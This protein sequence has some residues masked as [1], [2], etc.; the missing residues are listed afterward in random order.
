MENLQ[1][2]E[3]FKT[4]LVSFESG[5]GNLSVRGRVFPE[6]PEEFFSLI[7]DWLK[8][9]ATQPAPQTRMVL[10]L[11]Y[12]NSTSS[13]YIFRLCKFIEG[14]SENGNAATIVWEYDSDDED[15]KQ[16][17]EDYAEILKLN[18]DLK[19]VI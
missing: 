12:F 4:P 10:F 6:N 2:E 3:S 7:F 1:L 15:M 5:T 9:Y 19:A 18:F 8:E 13:E 11:S 17:G 14:I 16:I